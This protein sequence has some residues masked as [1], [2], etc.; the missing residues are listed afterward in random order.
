MIRL[1]I[2]RLNNAKNRIIW[3]LFKKLGKKGIISNNYQ[4]YKLFLEFVDDSFEIYYHGLYEE[5]ETSIIKKIVKEQMNVLDIGANIGYFSLMMANLIGPKG[6]VYAFE[7]NPKM[8]LRLKKNLEINPSYSDQIEINQLALGN[9]EGIAKLFCPPP[10]LEGLGG[11]R[12]TKRIPI[13]KTINVNVIT[14]DKYVKEHNIKKIDF[15][16]LDVEG[17]EYDVIKGAEDTLTKNHPIILFEAEEKN[18]APYDYHV[19]EVID[20][21]KNNGYV[22]EKIGNGPNF[23]AISHNKV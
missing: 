13:D 17:G 15:I 12:N 14:L 11:L 7:P 6:K 16:K 19:F 5:E 21:L 1:N 10:G 18:I 3:F 23:L 22:V 8:F 9:M 4:G 20:Y 2:N